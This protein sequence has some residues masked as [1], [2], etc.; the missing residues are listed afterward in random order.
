MM[1]D[2]KELLAQSAKEITTDLT[3][4]HE[5]ARIRHEN[6]MKI[7]ID[8][9]KKIEHDFNE[10]K[11]KTLTETQASPFETPRATRPQDLAYQQILTSSKTARV[12]EKTEAAPVLTTKEESMSDKTLQALVK[13]MDATMKN[14]NSKETTTDLPKFTGKDAQWERWY[15]LLRSYFQAKGWLETFDHPIGPGTPD[16][17]TPGFDNSINEKIYQKIQSKCYEGTAGTY[18]RMAAEFDGH[19]VGTKLRTRYHGYSTQKLESYKK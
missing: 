10:L 14:T 12:K 18:V 5:Q 4:K 3:A 13:M 16:N 8:A 1:A 9:V 7:Q 2:F 11:Q 19:G 6:E 15:E 17:L